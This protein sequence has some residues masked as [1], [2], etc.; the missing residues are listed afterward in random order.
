MQ[1]RLALKSQ[2]C[3]S[4]PLP[5]GHGHQRCA[6]FVPLTSGLSSPNISHFLLQDLNDCYHF[7][8]SITVCVLKFPFLSSCSKEYNSTQ[9]T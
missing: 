5:A 3:A 2:R 6:Q 1:T 4:L 9:S 8:L 7:D